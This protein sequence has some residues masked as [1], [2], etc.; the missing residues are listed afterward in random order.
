MFRVVLAVAVA[1]AAAVLLISSAGAAA[2][3]DVFTLDCGSAGTFQAI[4]AGSGSSEQANNTWTPAHIVGTHMTV[5][6][7]AFANVHGSF[8]DEQGV[9]HPFSEPDES[10]TSVPPNKTLVNCHFSFSGT[11]PGGGAFTFEGDVT[12]Y[13]TGRAD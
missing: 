6:P 2:E 3:K 10:K 13:F 4:G 11:D 9:V 12:V 1:A 5:V 7:V 8:T